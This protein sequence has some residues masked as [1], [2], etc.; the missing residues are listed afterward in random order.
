MDDSTEGLLLVMQLSLAKSRG[1]HRASHGKR[2][3]AW[4]CPFDVFESQSWEIHQD[5]LIQSYFT[6]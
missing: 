3:R 6:S 1:K 5:D 4:K 2:K